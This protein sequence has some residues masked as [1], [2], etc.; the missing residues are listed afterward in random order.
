MLIRCA[1]AN[2][3]DQLLDISASIP[4]GMTSMPFDK[5]VW[6]KRLAA[7]ETDLQKPPD[8]DLE[9]NYLLVL[10]DPQSSRIVGTAG[11]K[12]AVGLTYPFYNY[13]LSSEVKISQEL[14][15]RSST[16][17]LNLMNDFTGQT[18]LISLFLLSEYRS[19]HTGKFLSLCRFLFMSDFPERFSDVIFAEI[20]GWLNQQGKSPFWESV[21]RKFFKLPFARADYLNAVHGSGFISDLMPRFPL[22][23]ELLPEEAIEV[24]GKPHDDAVPAKKI[25]E[26]EGFRCEGVVDI[27]DGGPIMQCHRDNIRSMKQIRLMTIDSLTTRRGDEV[28]QPLC[29]LS[30]RRLKDYRL[31]LSYAD[32]FN[33]DSLAI[34]KSTAELLGV[35]VG[36]TIRLLEVRS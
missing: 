1:T 6:E 14:E 31:T 15:I 21:G 16:K 33:E 26:H 34:P 3:L 9:R 22:Y 12:T 7:V 32:F 29:I 4:T 25:L 19:R 10:E 24:I 28:N 13:R 23:L 18:E 36:N 5:A 20:R 8:L 35:E 27:F 11:I 30:N 17:L 2:D